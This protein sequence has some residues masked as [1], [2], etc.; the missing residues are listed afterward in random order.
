MA[1]RRLPVGL[2]VF[3]HDITMAAIAFLLGLW[4]RVG[5]LWTYPWEHLEENAVLFTLTCAVSFRARHLYRG[6]WRYA[7][8]NDLIAIAQASTLAVAAYVPLTFLFTRG[9][10]LP[11]SLPIITWLVLLALLGGPRMAYRLFKDG[12]LD[13]RTPPREIR[14]IPALL[15][16]AGDSAEVFVRA[17][18]RPDAHYRVLGILDADSS[19]VGYR[20]HGVEV[21]GPLEALAEVI[22]ALRA[23]GDDPQRVIVSADLPG[24][25][26]RAV[27]DAGD[28]AGLVVSRLPK[29]TELRNND[30]IEVR[31][32]AIEDL[33]NRPEA[34][35]DRQ[36]M[37]RLI[38]G[39]RVVVTGAGGSIGSELVRQICAFG[40][41][42]IALLDNGEFNLYAIDQ[43]VG[44]RW[45]GVPRS[46]L[47]ADVRDRDRIFGLF[48]EQRPDLVFHAAALKH[49]PMVEAHPSEGVLTNVMGTRNVADASRAAGVAAM[50]MISTDKAV[51]PTN[52]MG[53]TKRA[54]EG[55]C[56]AIDIEEA[57]RPTGMRI[58]TVR[59]GNVLGSTGSVVPLFTKQ[60]A[61]GGPLTVTHAEIER[62]FM[63]IREAV[64]LVLQAAVLRLGIGRDK[65]ESE[66]GKLFVLDMG[67]A[68]KIVDLARQ[69]IRLAG[70]RP[71]DDVMIEITGLR[72]GE[73]L[74]EELFH[75]QE[76]LL[77]TSFP[78]INA[79]APRVADF[80][81]MAR[82]LD[83]LI[84][85]ARTGDDAGAVKRLRA[86]V[87]EYAVFVDVP[88]VAPPYDLV[89]G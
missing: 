46:M 39:R 12:R 61:R 22:A 55:Y 60:L 47:L 20:I 80:A 5:E 74:K 65:A 23:K 37:A 19:R 45:P 15:V 29:I 6:V 41:S 2:L 89:R 1:R 87:P 63:T 7:S 44:E 50:V 26:V 67:D 30:A 28:A 16:G 85:V 79:A 62:Y 24:T 59:F 75:H 84:E 33:L 36:G 54:A 32:I 76:E 42:R 43:E 27:L 21:L 86:I 66:G 53:A 71:G 4:L 9:E 25:R 48:N 10:G 8:L 77:P 52:V 69:M 38:E 72:P 31:P 82:A 78:G 58:I 11:R 3:V 51:N 70:L 56:Q 57:R 83:G 35:L 18:A 34:N 13:F 14:Q 73:K 64:A 17:M 88:S 81:V 49:V 68:V 40:P